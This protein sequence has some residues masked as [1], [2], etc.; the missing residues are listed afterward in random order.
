MAQTTLLKCLT[1]RLRAHKGTVRVLGRVPG[2]VESAVPGRS[3]GFMPQELAL[4]EEFTAH[5]NFLFYGKLYGMSEAQIR[6][7]EAFLLSFLHL[8]PSTR[9][10][11]QLSGGQQRRVSL[12]CALL[13]SPPL[14][15]LDEP[16]VGVDPVLR[17]RIWSHLRT[18]SAE[19]STI[20]ITTHYIEEARQADYVGFMRGGRI[21]QEGRPDDIIAQH[22]CHSLEE[23]FLHLCRR[24]EE[25]TDQHANGEQSVQADAQ[26]EDEREEEEERR[27]TRAAAEE[28]RGGGGDDHPTRRGPSQEQS[29][30]VRD[31]SL[32][33]SHSDA[34]LLSP[35]SHRSDLSEAPSPPA[36]SSLLSSYLPRWSF[37]LACMWRNV[38]R[39]RLNIPALLFVFLLPSVQVILFCIA[40][41]KDPQ[42]IPLGLVNLDRGGNYSEAFA[43][44]L[45]DE[46]LIVR[47]FDSSDE[48]L[49]AAKLNEVWGYAV[50]PANYSDNLDGLFH[51]PLN[52]PYG[53]G[54]IIRYS[55]DASDEQIA[56]FITTAILQAY[57]DTLNIVLPANLSHNYPL[58]QLPPVYGTASSSFTDFVAPVASHLALPPHP[59]PPVLDRCSGLSHLGPVCSA[60]RWC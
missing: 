37:L 36:L 11:K 24:A 1:G 28:K 31:G 55:I 43:S 50:V 23:V 42:D 51:D 59:Q 21:L 52:H 17:A 45:G 38:T 39:F 12:A 34:A 15:L 40:I 48:A 46:G 60:V 18:L 30:T 44:H 27:R 20:I 7:R 41:G 33:G 29:T 13:H 3:V 10:I 16:T 35:S 58:Q 8:P 19:G 4:Y 22:S 5:Q 14:L 57:G 54:C 25:D 53:D 32:F 9:P 6:E 56:V 26:A 47:P 49:R 2:A